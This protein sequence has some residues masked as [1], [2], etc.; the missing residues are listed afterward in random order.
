MPY[1]FS[2]QIITIVVDIFTIKVSSSYVVDINPV[3]GIEYRKSAPIPQEVSSLCCFLLSLC[4]F[5][6]WYNP[7]FLLVSWAE[8]WVLLQKW[9][10]QSQSPEAFSSVLSFS[11]YM[12][13]DLIMPLTDFGWLFSMVRNRILIPFFC[14]YWRN[15]LSLTYNV[16]IFIN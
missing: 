1:S 15:C 6:V 7:I 12:G 10:C 5:L 8:M 16:G 14:T 2:N 9:S 4:R 13:L 3:W 11:S